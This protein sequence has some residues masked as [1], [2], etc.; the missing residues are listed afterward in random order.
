MQCPFCNSYYI[1]TITWAYWN[2]VLTQSIKCLSCNNSFFGDED[3]S[4]KDPDWEM[5]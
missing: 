2:G 4:N 3:E 1:E 5:E